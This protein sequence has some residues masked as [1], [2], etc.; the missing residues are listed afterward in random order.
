MAKATERKENGQNSYSFDAAKARQPKR[1]YYARLRW[2][3]LTHYS[4]GQ[5]HCACCAE[6]IYE[7]LAIDHIEGGGTKQRSELNHFGSTFYKWLKDN[8]FPTGYRVL[9]HNCN[10]AYGYYG[11]CPHEKLRLESGDMLSIEVIN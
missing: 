10:A 11:M 6:D 3:V 5:P 4:Q 7:F 1:S 8:N 2:L 9:C